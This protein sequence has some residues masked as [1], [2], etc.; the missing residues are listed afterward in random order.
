[1]KKECSEI[2]VERLH[3][4]VEIKYINPDSDANC[5]ALVTYMSRSYPYKLFFIQKEPVILILLSN[6]D[7]GDEWIVV[8]LQQIGK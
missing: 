5:D 6:P 1:M 8:N 3:I 7:A 2:L 4:Q